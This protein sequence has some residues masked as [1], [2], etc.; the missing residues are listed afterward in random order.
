MGFYLR[1]SF[2]AGPIRFNLSKSG[3]GASVG[4]KGFRVGTSARGRSYVHAGR[5]GLYYRKNLSSKTNTSFSGQKSSSSG[6]FTIIGILFFIGIVIQ[7]FEWAIQNPAVPIFIGAV[8]LISI[9][10]FYYVKSKKEKLYLKYKNL[11]DQCF[12]VSNKT[13]DEKDIIQIKQIRGD[14]SKIPELLIKIKNIEKEVY[15]ALLDKIIDDKEITQD[16]KNTIETFESI[17]ELDPSFKQQSKK[18]LFIL[19]YYDAIADHRITENELS[20]IKNIIDGLGLDKT[21]VIDEMKTI[22]EILRAQ[23][24]TLPLKPI[25]SVSIKIQKNEIPYYSGNGK[26]LSRKKSKNGSDDKYEYTIRREGDYVITDK[27]ILVVNDGSSTVNLKEVL[28]VD[29]DIDR[30]MIVISKSNSSTPVF[31]QTKDAIYTAKII[32]LLTS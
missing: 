29:V 15:T 10:I 3:I 23:N 11:L 5:G 12:V 19:Y 28:D 16:E 27:R 6:L 22:Q 31:I 2:S 14:I 4:V 9:S 18:E 30:Q 25:N 7:V 8:A 13:S 1:K 32:D 17:I 21:A 26:I 20:S 24:L